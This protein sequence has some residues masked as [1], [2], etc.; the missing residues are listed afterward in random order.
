MI[1]SLID[2]MEG[3]VYD[4]AVEAEV[5]A[6]SVEHLLPIL[7]KAYLSLMRGSE[8]SSFY[9]TSAIVEVTLNDETRASRINQTIFWAINIAQKIKEGGTEM[10]LS[11][12][13]DL[14]VNPEILFAYISSPVYAGEEED[15]TVVLGLKKPFSPKAIY[16][17]FS[18]EFKD[19]LEKEYSFYRESL[20]TPFEVVQFSIDFSKSIE[21]FFEEKFRRYYN[22]WIWNRI[23]VEVLLKHLHD[24]TF[25]FLNEKFKEEG[26]RPPFWFSQTKSLW[27]IHRGNMY[28]ELSEKAPRL[29]KFHQDYLKR[30]S[31]R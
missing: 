1:D 20:K 24:T 10:F 19:F 21:S 4:P 29:F 11:I 12:I 31:S 22:S 9:V 13:E 15:H 6:A 18:R 2:E 26:Y 14:G 16:I 25:R 7:K 3:R 27:F 30:F 17:Y 8:L 5:E 28:R 23:V